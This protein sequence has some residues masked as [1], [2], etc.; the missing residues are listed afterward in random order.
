MTDWTH[1][2][3]HLLQ[4]QR[5]MRLLNKALPILECLTAFHL[6][7]IGNPQWP[8]TLNN[9]NSTSDF[10]LK[11]YFNN[12][13]IDTSDIIQ[14][15]EFPVNEILLVG[16]KLLLKTNSND[17][18]SACLLSFQPTDIIASNE[19]QHKFITKTLIQFDQILRGYRSLATP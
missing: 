19:L 1:R 14:F 12:L 10:L 6:E 8:S 17:E 11:I 2:N 16:L 18:A 15:F 4:H 5:C 9:I 7:V 3:I 13:Y